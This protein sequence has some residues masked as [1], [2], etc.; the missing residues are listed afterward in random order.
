MNTEKIL[1]AFDGSE[2]ALRWLREAA[3]NGNTEAMI[4]L[5]RMS[6]TGVG[7]LQ[8]YGSCSPLHLLPLRWRGGDTLPT[9]LEH[10]A[11][12][13]HVH[14]VAFIDVTAQQFRQVLSRAQR[15]VFPAATAFRPGLG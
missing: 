8:H 14:R 12:V 7:L 3:E 2:N 13:R 10:H 9:L 6:R 15:L 4:V 11:E 5:G 1:I